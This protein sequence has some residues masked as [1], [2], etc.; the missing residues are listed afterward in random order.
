MSRDT[1]AESENDKSNERATAYKHSFK[2]SLVPH[3]GMRLFIIFR[4]DRADRADLFFT[5]KMLH[6]HDIIRK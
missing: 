5:G 3:Y 2:S 6:R 4:P 1:H